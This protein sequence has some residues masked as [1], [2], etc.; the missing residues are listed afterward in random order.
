MAWRGVD[1]DIFIMGPRKL[2][3]QA[4]IRLPKAKRI[5]EV[6]HFLLSGGYPRT[7]MATKISPPLIKEVST[8][9]RIEGTAD[10]VSQLEVHFWVG[11][12]DEAPIQSETFI[13]RTG[14]R[15]RFIWLLS[16]KCITCMIASVFEQSV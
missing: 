3:R 8:G 14:G 16:C 6:D 9:R 11:S 15:Q 13:F 1:A 12:E 10:G 7:G 5:F 4:F 2:R